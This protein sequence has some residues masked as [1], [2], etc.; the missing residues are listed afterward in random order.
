MADFLL[1][2]IAIVLAGTA[3]ASYT[4]IKKGLIYDWITI[5]MIVAGAVINVLTGQWNGFLYA[6]VVFGIGFILYY[7]GK[8]GGGDVKLFS[9]IAILI[10]EFFGKIFILNVFVFSGLAGLL[11]VS[12]YYSGKYLRK[13]GLKKALQENRA[14]IQK[15]ILLGTALAIYFFLVLSWGLV[16]SRYALVLGF[17][18]LFGLLFVG[19]EKGIR[20]EIFL[21]KIPVSALEEDEIIATEHFDKQMLDKLGIGLKGVLD[22]KAEK[23]LLENGV[24][25]VFVYRDLPKFAPFILLGVIAAIVFPDFFY[26]LV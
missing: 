15:S 12:V 3:I 6:G 18:M 22:K 10:P 19:L 26:L 5:P 9:A 23:V 13:V 2:Q 4:D 14:G 7:T 20:R 16:G 24:K 8:I 11:F 21:K 1:L 25:E 17:P